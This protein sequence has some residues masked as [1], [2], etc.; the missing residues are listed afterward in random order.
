MGWPISSSSFSIHCNGKTWTK[1]TNPII[2]IMPLLSQTIRMVSRKWILFY[3][4]FLNKS[5]EVRFSCLILHT[6]KLEG[7]KWNIL[8]K[9]SQFTKF[10]WGSIQ[11]KISLNSIIF[12]SGTLCCYGHSR[13]KGGK[14]R[15]K[16]TL[17]RS[18]CEHMYSSPFLPDTHWN[19][20]ENIKDQRNIK[21]WWN[22][23]N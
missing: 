4:Q 2:L 15:F 12:H 3:L 20:K 13:S 8:P 10:L 7:G 9:A 22:L 21:I 14:N 11:N 17:S 5:G 23:F 6:K 16:L 19:T 18:K 1:L